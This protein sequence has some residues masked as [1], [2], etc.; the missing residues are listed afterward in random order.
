MD[1]Q[2][3]LLD[4]CLASFFIVIG[5]FLRAKFSIFQ[6]F[7][8]PS[9]MIAGFL[10]LALGTQGLDVLFFSE[11]I[12]SY[13][14]LLIIIIFSAVGIN[15]FSLSKNEIKSEIDRIGSYFSYKVLAQAIQFCFA[16]LLSILIISKIFPY[17]NN[18]FGLL[19]AAGF[20]GGH[21]TA[22]AVG[23][24]FVKLGDSSAMDIAMTFAT[25]GL[26]SGIFG[27]LFFIKLGTKRGW[28]K[29]IKNFQYI[30][31]DLKTGLIPSENRKSLGQ[32]TISPMVLDPI[33]WHL[34]LLLIA[35]GLGIILNK[36]ILT[37]TGLDLP[38]YLVAFLVAILIFIIFRKT[39]VWN[40]V[41]DDIINRLSGTATDYLVF[42]GISSIKISVVVEYALPI[43]L[44]LLFGIIIVVMTLMFF[45]RSMNKD[46]WFERAI[47][48]FGYSTGVFAIGFILL[49]IVDPQNLSKTLNDTALVA[50][51]TTPFEMFAWSVGPYMLLGGQHWQFVGLY[52]ALFAVCIILNIVF[53]WWWF[54]LPLDRET[55]LR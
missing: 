4:F 10:A 39:T 41:D 28:T 52:L 32:E 54:D 40:Y 47:F 37:V 17:I 50:P 9:S 5:Q 3:V 36:W 38:T 12:G 33:A 27:G 34:G 49:R 19:L 11:N 23:S 51:F 46:S 16:P 44:L 53:K 2:A 43:L 13:A 8:V 48:V 22:A 55:K 35:T 30:S 21:G 45:G 25:M 18:G 15:G 26:L 42:F 20:S 1:V 7:F 14:G 24:T 31:G 29:Y 6:R